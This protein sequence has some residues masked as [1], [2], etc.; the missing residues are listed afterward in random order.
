MI[1]VGIKHFYGLQK[2][3]N[4]SGPQ[5]GIS[6]NKEITVVMSVGRLFYSLGPV[7]FVFT[8]INFGTTIH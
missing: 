4:S 2:I 1:R 7:T 3:I 8:S 6:A 5:Q